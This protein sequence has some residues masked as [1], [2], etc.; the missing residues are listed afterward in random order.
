MRP[1]D[2]LGLALNVTRMI[3]LGLEAMWSAVDQ[4]PDEMDPGDAV[5]AALGTISDCL[6]KA[7]KQPASTRRTHD[8]QPRPHCFLRFLR[9]LRVFPALPPP[10][11]LSRRG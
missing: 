11:S 4:L 10:H 9:F 7:S 8:P 1:A 2:E 3:R 5:R 6:G